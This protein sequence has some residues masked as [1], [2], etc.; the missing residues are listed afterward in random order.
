MLNLSQKQAFTGA[1]VTA[2][3]LS[4]ACSVS[5]IYCYVTDATVPSLPS[6]VS[7]KRPWT[8][9]QTKICVPLEQFNVLI[10]DFYK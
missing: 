2:A 7:R 8:T 6:V 10:A 4:S 9:R 5:A 1:S 3:T